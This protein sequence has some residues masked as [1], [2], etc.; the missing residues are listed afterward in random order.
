MYMKPTLTAAL[1]TWAII[2]PS[3][4]LLMYLF[5]IQLAAMPLLVRNFILTAVLVPWML[6]VA[7]PA[8]NF[9]I[10]RFTKTGNHDNTNR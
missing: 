8:L 7:M 1:K 2:Y 3:I 9:I 6:F 4:T 10:A 5:G